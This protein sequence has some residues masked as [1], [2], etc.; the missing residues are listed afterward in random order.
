D[1][2]GA[3]APPGGVRKRGGDVGGPYGTGQAVIAFVGDPDRVVFVAVTQHGQHRAEYLLPGDAHVVGGVDEQR[4]PHIPTA[5]GRSVVA[6][7]HHAGTLL[8][9]GPD[10]FLDLALVPLREQGSDV[11][12]LV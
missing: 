12:G 4:R 6:T 11:G 1:P 2:V 9:T 10:V 3:G 5:L 8:L 7:E